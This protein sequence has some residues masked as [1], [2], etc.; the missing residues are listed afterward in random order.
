MVRPMSSVTSRILAAA[1]T[2]SL[3]VF[4]AL[5][6]SIAVETVEKKFSTFRKIKNIKNTSNES[7]GLISSVFL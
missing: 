2:L 3:L 5:C 1:S 4:F 6:E 7:D